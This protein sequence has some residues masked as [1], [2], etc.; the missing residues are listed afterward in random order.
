[1]Q[2]VEDFWDDILSQDTQ[3]IL[4]AVSRLDVL[5]QKAVIQHLKRMSLEPGWHPAQKT[6]A[7]YALEILD[8]TNHH[9]VR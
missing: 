3:R 6:A 8:L 7:S 5:T 4:S 9:S 2:S 1:M